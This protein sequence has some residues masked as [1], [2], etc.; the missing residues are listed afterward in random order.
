MKFFNWLYENWFKISL[1]LI[2]LISIFGWFYWFQLRPVSIRQFCW[3]KAYRETKELRGDRIDA[4]YLYQRCF[5]EKGLKD[6]Y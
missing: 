3:A 4:N 5:R 1:F 6:N 2:I